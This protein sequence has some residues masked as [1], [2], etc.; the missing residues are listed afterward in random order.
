MEVDLSSRRGRFQISET[1]LLMILCLHNIGGTP[2]SM[3]GLALP[4]S[5]FASSWTLRALGDWITTL[6]RVERREGE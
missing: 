5:L 2:C 4:N 6:L 1:E 3:C